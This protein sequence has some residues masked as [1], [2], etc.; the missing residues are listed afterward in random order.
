MSAIKLAGGWDGDWSVII[1][2]AK[3]AGSGNIIKFFSAMGKGAKEA[4]SKVEA[5]ASV[6]QKGMAGIS[7]GLKG[8]WNSLGLFGKIGIV[9]T[10]LGTL[11][12]IYQKIQNAGAEANQK[13]D[14]SVSKYEQTVSELESVNS[15][16]SD[17]QRYF[18][19]TS[20]PHAS[21]RSS[22]CNFT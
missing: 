14:E 22:I 6:I 1:G 3:D 12:G 8:A 19:A 4:A 20:L 9:I 2:Y 7:G 15:E 5:S 17:T 13:M 11:Y 21:F 10:A 18:I 16:L